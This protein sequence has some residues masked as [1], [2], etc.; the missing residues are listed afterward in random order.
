MDN[1]LSFVKSEAARLLAH[2][3]NSD[4]QLQKDMTV[5]LSEEKDI[6]LAIALMSLYHA[7]I[8]QAK[9]VAYCAA[10]S[11]GIASRTCL[12]ALLEIGLDLRLMLEWQDPHEN[13]ISFLTTS[14]LEMKKSILAKEIGKEEWITNIDL[15]LDDYA[16]VCPITVRR[17]RDEHQLRGYIKHWSGLKPKKIRE[18]LEKSS[19]PSLELAYHYSSWDAHAKMVNF[20]YNFKIQDNNMIWSSVEETDP[21]LLLDDINSAGIIFDNMSSLMISS[22]IFKNKKDSR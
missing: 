6:F 13:A 19:F 21:S 12:R 14:Q 11:V 3:E 5:S 9:A 8:D 2:I 20:R 10:N 17:L 7:G 22:P 1:E 4:L 18:L 16:R 15:N